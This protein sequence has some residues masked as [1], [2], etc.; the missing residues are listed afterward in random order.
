MSPPRT[1]VDERFR[2]PAT[3]YT[4]G[5]GVGNND[6]TLSRLDILRS[7]SSV[8]MYFVTG[9][10]HE[11]RSA[12]IPTVIASLGTNSDRSGVANSYAYQCSRSLGAECYWVTEIY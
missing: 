6:S 1:S 9:S 7:P 10:R 3:A 2:D 5:L 4:K 12:K 8:G 11:M